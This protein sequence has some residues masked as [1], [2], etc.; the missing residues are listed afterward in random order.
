M[1]GFLDGLRSRLTAGGV[2]ELEQLKQFKRVEVESSREEFDGSFFIWDSFFYKGWMLEK[3]YSI[4]SQK[5][6]EYF[7]WRR[8]SWECWGFS[9]IHLPLFSNR[10]FF[11]LSS[12][13]R[14]ELSKS[15]NGN[16]LV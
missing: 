2:R 5:I 14:N 15:R 1:N 8:L 7:H 10:Q 3:Q 9:K 13:D 6:A 16:G 11:F 4:D 12:E